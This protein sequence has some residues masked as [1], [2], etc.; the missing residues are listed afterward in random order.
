MTE[1]SLPCL[2]RFTKNTSTG[3]RRIIVDSEGTVVVVD[4]QTGE[5]AARVQWKSSRK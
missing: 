4:E 3:S 1:K 5:E 2:P